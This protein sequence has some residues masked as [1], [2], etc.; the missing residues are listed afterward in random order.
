MTEESNCL[1]L[2]YILNSSTEDL[3]EHFVFCTSYYKV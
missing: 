3:L 2:K 1:L